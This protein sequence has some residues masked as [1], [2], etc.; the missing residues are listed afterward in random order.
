MTD[1]AIVESVSES[2]D[3]SQQDDE[4]APVVKTKMS[5]SRAFNHI[6]QLYEWMKEKGAFS[7]LEILQA[8]ALMDK[9]A[10]IKEKGIKQK[11]IVDFFK[12]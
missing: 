6:V 3:Q 12:A 1:E 7:P 8:K 5:D 11:T 2:S 9:T 10:E 4:P